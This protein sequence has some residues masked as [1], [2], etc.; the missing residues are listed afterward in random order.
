MNGGEIDRAMAGIMVMV[1]SRVGLVDELVKLLR[2]M[3]MEGTRLDER[4]YFSACNA[5]TEAGM[6]VHARWLQESFQVT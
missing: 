3:K 2:D 1:F 6:Q 4:L 5:L